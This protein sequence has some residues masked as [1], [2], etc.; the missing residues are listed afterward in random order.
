MLGPISSTFYAL[1]DLRKKTTFLSLK[2]I[3]I[4]H[5]P[6]VLYFVYP[7]FKQQLQCM[8]SVYLCAPDR[9]LNIIEEI[10]SQHPSLSPLRAPFCVLHGAAWSCQH[11]SEL[12][13]AGNRAEKTQQNDCPA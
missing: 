3:Y 13:E 10:P 4:L 1:F 7:F 6:Y 12:Q 5:I 8:T 2:K 11:S 9:K